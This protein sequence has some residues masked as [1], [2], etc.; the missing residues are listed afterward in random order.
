MQELLQQIREQLNRI[1]ENLPPQQKVLF[2]A[3][4]VILLVSMLVAIFLASRPVMVTLVQSDDP[5]QLGRIANYLGEQGVSFESAQNAILVDEGVRNRARMMIAQEGLIGSTAG[6]GFELFDELRLGMTQQMFDMHYRRALENKLSRMITEGDPSVM[7]AYVTLTIPE[8]SLFRQ[9]QAFPSASVKLIS[10]SQISQRAVRGVQY[11]VAAAVPKLTA[12]NVIV[13]DGSNNILSEEAGDPLYGGASK[14]LEIQRAYENHIRDNVVRQ[15]QSYIKNQKFNVSVVVTQNWEQR[16]SEAVHIESDNQAPVSERSYSEQSTSRGIL[17]PP[18]PSSNIQDTGI[19]AE[20]DATGSK[21]EESLINYQY[22]WMKTFT[23]EDIG[24]IEQIN[25]A[26][27]IDY[28]LNDDDGS[29]APYTQEELDTLERLLRVAAGLSPQP[30]TGDPNHFILA[31]IPFDDTL[32]RD[33]A[34]QRMWENITSIVRSLLPLLLLAVLGYFA[35]IFFQRAFAT[36]ELEV[37]SMEEEVPIEPVTEAKELTLSQLGL[38]E[39]GDIASLPAEEQ[40]R[41]KMQEHVINY[42]AEKPEEV[43]AIIKAWLSS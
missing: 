33:L 16:R 38:A 19:G 34:R 18:G 27:G 32:E 10:R 28:K 5:A 21:I 12:E 29:R 14:K 40:R 36:P 13:A 17:G 31:S 30:L 8:E 11:L 42:A 1:W 26:V 20:G 23:Q 41:L 35:Y 22:P 24:E 2:V 3:A 4:P 25:V 9:D 37:D 6:P 15:L 39:F 7:H 43:A